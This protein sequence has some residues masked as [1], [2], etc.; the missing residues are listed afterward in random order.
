MGAVLTGMALGLRQALEEPEERPPI[1][2]DA[3]EQPFWPP[4]PLE[5]HFLPDAPAQTWVVVRPWL[6]GER[7]A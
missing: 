3:G 7:Q 6:L 4:R 5:L 2:V 1:V